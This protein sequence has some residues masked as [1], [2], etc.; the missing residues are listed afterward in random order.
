MLG[1]PFFT[2]KH[3]RG[4]GLGLLLAKMAVDRACGSLKLSNRPGGGARAEVILPLE[5]KRRDRAGPSHDAPIARK[6]LLHMFGA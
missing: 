6:K 2:T 3:D 1:K 4:T 5:P